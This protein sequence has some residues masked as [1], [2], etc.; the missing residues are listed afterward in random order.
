MSSIRFD[1]FVGG[2]E[3]PVEELHLVHDAVGPAFLR[4]AVVGEHDE[5]RVVE[6]AHVAQ[7]VDEPS[8]LVVGVVE[9]RGE[10]LLEATGE[11]P[12]ILGQVVPRVDAGVAR[13][14]PCALGDDTRRELAFEPT[15]PGD[16]P[17]VVEL[18]PVLLH[19]ARGCLVRGM[20]GAERDVREERAIGPHARGV[21]HHGEELVDQVFG[22]VVAV[23]RLARR[24]DEVVVADEFGMELVGLAFEEAVEPVEAAGEW[25]LVERSRRRA[26]F[27]RG[28][29]PLADTERGVA[30]LA[31]HLGNGGG[32]VADVAEHVGEAGAE[33]RHAPASRRRA[34]IAR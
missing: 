21:G 25:P 20:G 17:A 34:A 2:L 11:P 1:R 27:H 6:L 19:V 30:L 28:E 10:R 24:C 18:P 16:V 4:G 15:L 14:E 3:D 13:R 9:E 31:Q 5:H 29:V 7:A 8:D 22:E 32:M 33:V 23:L 26:L 12:L